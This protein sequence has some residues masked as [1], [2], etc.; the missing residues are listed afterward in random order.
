[1]GQTTPDGLFTMT[2][3][4][5]LGACVNAPMIQ[6]NNE[7]VYEDLNPENVVE[8]LEAL[9]RGDAKI[10]P[11]TDRVNSE[12]PQG[13]T[14]LTDVEF[15]NSEIRFTRDFAKA[16]QEWEDEMAKPAVKK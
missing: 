8:L 7:H 3:V 10:G 15:L 5:C 9:K 2:E 1:M 11:Q 14:S 16:K 6:I 12:G 13:R 4:E